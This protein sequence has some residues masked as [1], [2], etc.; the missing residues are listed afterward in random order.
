[1]KIQNDV[2]KIVQ[3]FDTRGHKKTLTGMTTS[4]FS[5]SLDEDSERFIWLPDTNTNQTIEP[6]EVQL[7]V[8]LYRKRKRSVTFFLDVNDDKQETPRAFRNKN[9]LAEAVEYRDYL[10]GNP[11]CTHAKIAQHFNAQR[12]RVSRL[13]SLVRRL[14][15]DFVEQAVLLPDTTLIGNDVIDIAKIKNRQKQ[16]AAIERLLL[17]ANERIP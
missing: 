4:G 12:E 11:S 9:I 15:S 16:Q 7:V 1:M 5:L 10:K 3:I 17:T 8:N 2:C 13:L 6:L 14:P